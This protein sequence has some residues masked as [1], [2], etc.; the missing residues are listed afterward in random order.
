[1]GRRQRG[2]QESWRWMIKDKPPEDRDNTTEEEDWETVRKKK[3]KVSEDAEPSTTIFLTNLPEMVPEKDIWMEIRRYGFLSDVYFPRKRDLKGKRFVFARFKK[4]RDINKLVHALN[5]VWFG[6]IRIKANVS[7]FKREDD[8]EEGVIGSQMVDSGGGVRRIVEDPVCGGGGVR[9]EENSRRNE[10]QTQPL[11]RK[12][13]KAWN[14]DWSYAEAVIGRKNTG[15]RETI[16]LSKPSSADIMDWNKRTVCMEAKTIQ[17]LCR[18][19]QIPSELI[20]DTMEIRYLGGLSILVTFGSQMVT[21]EFLTNYRKQWGEYFNNGNMWKEN[22][23]QYERI[24]WVSVFGIPGSLRCKNNLN[25]IASSIG[26]VVE[27][28]DISIE[29]GD[30]SSAHIGIIVKTGQ[31]INTEVDVVYKEETFKCWVSEV[32]GSWSPKFVKD[33][34][35]FVNLPEFRMDDDGYDNRENV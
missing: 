18:A 29:D 34:S 21:T 11:M 3:G 6:D 15:R 31:L 4:I 16:T 33:E 30:L 32:L 24:A 5:N 22:M 9:Y 19:K 20:P 26:K 2:G 35:V 7:K 17:I 28:G 25:A 23:N 12:N 10:G 13:Q 14:K 8:K 27:V 1:M